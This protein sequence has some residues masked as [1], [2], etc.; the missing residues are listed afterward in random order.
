MNIWLITTGEIIP[1]NQ[2][3][4]SRTGLLS[5]RLLQAGHQ[6]S[7]W[8][9][10]FD[11]QH[12]TFLYK[13]D[14][15]MLGLEGVSLLYVHAK[16]GYAKNVSWQRL[17]N[18][19]QVA[20]RFRSLARIKQK[21]DLIYCSFPTIDLSYEAV[22][23]GREFQVPVIVDVRDLWPDIFLD[24]FPSMLHP[25]IKL[26]LLDYVRKTAYALKHCTAITAVSE[27]YLNWGLAKGKRQRTAVD[28]VYPLGYERDE[29][30]ATVGV[31]FYSKMGLDPSKITVL[32]VG[33]FGQ[34]YQL[35]TVIEA[36]RQLASENRKDIQFVLT[37]DG[38]KMGEWKALANGLSNV[39]FT[40]W[41]GKQELNSLLQLA[42]IGLM[43]YSKGAPQGLPNKLFEYMSAGIPIL[44]SLEGETADLLQQ[45][46]MGMSYEA[47]GATSLLQCLRTLCDDA[48]LRK[49]MG[50][51]GLKRFELEFDSSIVYANLV[52]YLENQIK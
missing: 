48:S 36:A 43:A 8:T 11:H 15:E 47:D 24:P 31:A 27:G 9:T 14:T 3:R 18:H 52:A 16:Q 2:E 19:H 26:A 30:A 51:N 32:F 33:T 6:V 38:E 22:R 20:Q 35:S 12:K 37:G 44:S 39:I 21:P 34:T 5:K 25:F 7:W 28:K 42:S 10:T 50:Q 4:Y 46:S 23:Y 49:Q 17:C 29:I 45:H 40:G 13:E 41:V 1:L